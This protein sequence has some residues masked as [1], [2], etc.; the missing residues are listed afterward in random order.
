MPIPFTC[1]HCGTRTEVSEEYAGQTGPCAQCGKSVTI[2]LPHAPAQYA[3]PPRSSSK[4]PMLVIVLVCVMGVT[5]VCGGI[6]VAL[7]LPAIQ[8]A[9]EAARRAA[10]T[11]NMKQ[12]SLAMHNYEAVHGEFPPAYSTDEDGNPLHSWRVLILPYMEGQWLYDQIDLEQ[13]WDSPQNRVFA[14]MMPME[15]ACPSSAT[16]D[17]ATT[18]YMMI[19]GPGT[20][21]D[22]PTARKIA[23]ITDG[24]SQTL[25]VVEVSGMGVNWMEPRDLDAETISFMVNDGTSQGISSDHASVANAAMCDGS[26]HSISSGVSPNEIKAMSTIDGGEMVTGEALY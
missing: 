9:R 13:P 16:P 25:M 5:V 3:P 10:C 4:G 18:S 19:V 22:G 24:T 14:D 12:I 20:I 6:L 23:E 26:V 11:N 7:L 17:G 15:Y 2:P 21:S 8:A 1:P